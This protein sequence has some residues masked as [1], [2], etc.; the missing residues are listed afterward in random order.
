MHFGFMNAILLC[1]D[2]QHVSATTWNSSNSSQ[3]RLYHCSPNWII[4]HHVYCLCTSL[5]RQK[6]LTSNILCSSL[7]YHLT[8][9]LMKSVVFLTVDWSQH[10]INIHV[11]LL[12]PPRRYPHEWPKHNSPCMIKLHSWNQSVYVGLFS[13]FHTSEVLC[14]VDIS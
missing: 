12:L 9:I 6:F 5:H 13:K 7:F 11:F 10:T 14:C 1:S 3:C 2:H 8:S 4:I